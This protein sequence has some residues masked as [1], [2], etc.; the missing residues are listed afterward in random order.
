MSRTMR[1]FLFFGLMVLQWAIPGKMLLSRQEV[2]EK[3]T[4]FRFET[5]PFDPVDPFRGKYITLNFAHERV[6][7]KA[8][9]SLWKENPR[10]FLR[11]KTDAQGFARIASVSKKRPESVTDYLEAELQSTYGDSM[12]VSFPFNRFY[13]EEFKAGPAERTFR[14]LQGKKGI[15][16]WAEVRIFEGEAVLT[17]VKIQGK[18]LK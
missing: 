15:K 8:A 12:E 5:R 4:L 1:L 6:Y 18:S 10:V 14:E 3:G 13:M 16:T 17:D 9:D 2:L 7:N 11:F